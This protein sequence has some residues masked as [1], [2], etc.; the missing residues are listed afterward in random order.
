MRLGARAGSQWRRGHGTAIALFVAGNVNT[1][2]SLWSVGDEA[3][4]EFVTALFTKLKA[5][6]NATQALTATER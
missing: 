3:T 5:G 1:F 6:Q 4:A 2:M